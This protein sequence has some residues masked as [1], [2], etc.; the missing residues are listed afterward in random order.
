[1]EL[2]ES[3]PQL[4]LSKNHLFMKNYCG[5]SQSQDLYV[6]NTGTTAVIYEWKKFLREDHIKSKKSDGI[7][8]VFCHHAQGILQPSETKRFVFTFS[9]SKPGFFTEEW[10]LLTDPLLKTPIPQVIVTGWAYEDDL[11]AA[12]RFYM[13]E[14]LNKRAVVHSAEEVISDIVRSVRTPTPPPPDLEDPKQCQEQFE[15][16]NLQYGVWY[17]PEVVELINQLQEKV[18]PHLKPEDQ[19]L[20]WDLQIDLLKKMI[21]KVTNQRKRNNFEER[22]DFLVKLAKEKPTVRSYYYEGAKQAALEVAESIPEIHDS[23]RQELELDEV[24]FALPWELTEEEKEKLQKEKAEREA[25]KAKLQRGKKPKTEEELEKDKET[26]KERIHQSVYELIMDKFSRMVGHDKYFCLW[27]HIQSLTM[28]RELP[29]I[30]ENTNRINK[31]VKN[32]NIANYNISKSKIK[33]LNSATLGSF[34]RKYGLNEIDMEGKRVMIRLNLDVPLSEEVWEEEEQEGE[35]T[36]KCLKREIKDDTLLQNALPTLRFCLDHLAKTIIIV[37]NLGPR[38]GMFRE[39]HS[40]LPIAEYFE[41]QL[42]QKIEYIKD[43]EIDDFEERIEDLPENSLICFENT[44]SHP[45]EFG[46]QIDREGNIKHCSAQEVVRFRQK[47]VSYCEIYINECIGDNTCM[48]ILDKPFCSWTNPGVSSLECAEFCQEPLVGLK[49]EQEIK[50]LSNLFRDSDKSF[51]VILGGNE[52]SAVSVL[53]KTLIAFSL[54]DLVDKIYMGGDMALLFL[55]KNYP[56]PKSF[57]SQLMEF[58]DKVLEYAQKLGKEILLPED[59]LI[60][61]KPQ[62]E[63]KDETQEEQEAPKTEEQPEEPEQ[64]QEEL[65][66]YHYATNFNSLPVGQSVPEGYEIVGFGEHSQSSLSSLLHSSKNFYWNGSL[67]LVCYEREEFHLMDKTA[68]EYFRENRETRN[69]KVGIQDLEQN[70]KTL[71]IPEEV[72]QET[73]EA[74]EEDSEKEEVTPEQVLNSIFT[75]RFHGGPLTAAILQARKVTALELLKEHPPPRQKSIEEDTSYLEG[76]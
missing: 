71:L 61:E 19:V 63:E 44:A 10:D 7:R 60:A 72:P 27:D 15:Y 65:P 49:L 50:N 5:K 64:A 54:L 68:L 14:E 4:E 53:D 62:P 30:L 11:Y 24:V 35:V 8:R 31:H 29:N 48:E 45:C 18:T 12:D 67:D 1:M 38:V 55:S 37:G 47:L 6:T 56:V 69:L 26:S 39:E 22:L 13:E 28:Y 52:L 2:E 58:V 32:S 76:I 59:Y 23:I 66:W 46:F 73:S 57:D 51:L 42:D 17:T 20:D 74:S 36:K 9:S 21:G 70:I 33:P 75:H 41:K 43:L 16:R 25:N 34:S 40:I 3:Y